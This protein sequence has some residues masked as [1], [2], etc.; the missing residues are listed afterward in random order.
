MSGFFKYFE[1]QYWSKKLFGDIQFGEAASKSS[2]FLQQQLQEA[3]GFCQ[4]L[5]GKLQDIPGTNYDLGL[6][7]MRLGNFNDAILRFRMVCF[8]VPEH[9]DAHYHLGR[10]LAVTGNN[11]D[12]R[13]EFEKVL[14][15]K[16][17]YSDVA[18]QMARIDKPGS[19]QELP[20]SVIKERA[21]LEAYYF[22]DDYLDNGYPGGE[23]L[24][25]KLLEQVTDKNPQLEILDLG[26]GTGLCGQLLRDK[27]V[28][29]TITG[30]DIVPEMVELCK[31]LQLAGEQPVYNQVLEQEIRAFL[32]T[33][34]EK[35][36]V[37]LGDLSFH[38]L[39]D[40]FTL[41]PLLHRA[42]KPKGVLAFTLR[43]DP[44][45]T[46]G[47]RF[48]NDFEDFSYSEPYLEQ[49]FSKARFT[50]AGVTPFPISE[51]EEGIVHLFTA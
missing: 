49:A 46:S 25:T 38:Y 17:G 37:I 20:L 50:N 3:Q 35:Y 41:A 34:Q 1:I 13:K 51:D 44:E 9:V 31:G 18:Y 10:C 45:V 12:A 16:P 19:I 42:L 36:D 15:L 40:M 32:Q 26:C 5:K 22:L 23:L 27:G 29:R 43:K 8:L 30:I 39:G 33:N 2:S 48:N 24:V 21:G 47:H 4:S 14:S 6:H 28:A 11:D 7:H